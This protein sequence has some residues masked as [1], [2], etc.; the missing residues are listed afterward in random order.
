MRPC[1]LFGEENLWSLTGG[2]GLLYESWGAVG[3]GQLVTVL[4]PL[5]GC[6]LFSWFQEGPSWTFAWTLVLCLSFFVG[7]LVSWLKLM[8]SSAMSLLV[9]LTAC[10]ER[11]PFATGLTCGFAGF[12]P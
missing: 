2:L 9:V 8:V 12:C 1:G 3:S 10:E 4:G 5:W 11:C 7:P 6:P